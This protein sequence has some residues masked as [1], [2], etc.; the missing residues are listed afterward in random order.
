MVVLDILRL[1][2]RMVGL[3]HRQWWD[4]E[5]L[6]LLLLKWI[7]KL[8]LLLLLLLLGYLVL[9]V[10]DDKLFPLAYETLG[11]YSDL[12]I[13]IWMKPNR[14]HKLADLDFF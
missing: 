13:C 11:L 10:V 8:L 4:H 7:L 5:T 6:S 3:H 2:L 12:L 1:L 14:V 9:L